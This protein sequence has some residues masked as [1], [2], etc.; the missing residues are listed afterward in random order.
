MFF[1]KYLLAVAAVLVSVWPGNGTAGD[2]GNGGG[3]GAVPQIGAAQWLWSAGRESECHLRKPFSLTEVPVAASIVITADN[4][5]E[6][7]VNGTW[8]GSDEGAGAEVWQSV[9]RYDLKG[10]LARGPNVIAIHGGDLGGQAGVV[11]AVR[12]EFKDQPPLEFATDGTWK[13]ARQGR[14]SDYAHPEFVESAAWTAAT[15]V[16]PMGM[17]PW[18]RLAWSA[19][20]KPARTVGNAPVALSPPDRDFAWPGELIFLGDDCSVYV[21]IRGDAWG[22]CFR[23]G[24]WSRA[25][26]EFDLPCPS[27]IGRKLFRLRP[28]SSAPQPTLLFDA[29]SGCIGSP[30]V[31]YDGRGIFMS[32]A[33]EG[34]KFFHIYQI[35]LAGGEPRRLTEGPFHDLDPVELPDG[36]IAFSSTR[37]GTFEEYHSPPSRALFVMNADGGDIHP[38]TSTPIFDNEPKVMADGRLIF[39]RSDNFFDRAKVETHLHAIRPDGT[40]G[41]T[42]VG[43]EVGPEYGVR[44]RAF[45]YGSPAPLPDGRLA[46]ISNRGNFVGAVGGPEREFHRLPDSLGDLAPLPDGRLLATVLRR[47]GRRMTSDVI[48]VIDPRD[49]RLVPIFESAAGSV[50]SPVF[51]GARARPPVLV[52]SI[53]RARAG[54]PGATGFLFCQDVRF[55]QNTQADWRQI[56]AMRVLGAV[57]LTTRSSHSHIVHAGHETVELGTVPIAP[58]GSFFVEVPADMPL[59][60]Q[61]V[62]AEG[63]SELNEMSWIYVRP[64]ERRSCLG[65][66]HPRQAA[67]SVEKR[68]ALALQA[69]PLKLLGQGEPHRFRGN[70]SGVTGMMDLQFERFRETASLNRH[71]DVAGPLTTGRQ[72]IE[73]LLRQLRGADEGLK[74]SAAQRLA[75]RRDHAA[76]GVLVERLQDSSREVR[77]AAAL[78]LAACGTRESVPGLL[79]AMEDRDPVVAAAGGMALANLVGGQ[80]AQFNAFAEMVERQRQVGV[81][82]DWFHKFSWAAIE[83][84]VI[85]RIRQQQLDP[86]RWAVTALGHVGGEAAR[87]ALREFVG[88]MAAQNPYP[89]F[90][91]DNRTDTFTYSAASP[92]NPR[93]LQEAVR[94]LGQLRDVAAIPLLQRLVAANLAPKTA[95][96][97]LAEAALEALGRIATPEAEA[98]LL[99]LFPRFK[100]YWEYVGWYSDHPA[101]YAC[102]SSPLHARLIEA[103]EAIASPRAAALVPGLIRSVPTDPDR[104]LFLSNDAYE[105]LVGRVIRRSGRG[106]EVVDTC[107]AI[108]GDPQARAGEEIKAAVAA[109]WAAWA[110]HPG[111]ENRAAQILSLVCR[112]RAEEPRIRKAFERYRARP[113]ESIRRELGNPT[114]TPVRHWV[115]FYLARSLGHLRDPNS[116]GAL[117]GVLGD[118]LN[119]ARHGRPDPAQPEIHFLHLEYTPCWRAAAAHALGWIGDRRAVPVLLRAV[120]NLDNAPDVRHAAA[121]ALGR[122]ADPASASALHELAEQYPEVST[123]RVLFAAS[124][125]AKK[126]GTT[127]YGGI[128]DE[129]APAPSVALSEP[130]TRTL[131]AAEAEAVLRRDWLFQAEGQPLAERARQEIRWARALA[132]RLGRNARAPNL[133]R[134]LE[135]LTRLEREWEALATASSSPRTA[136][137]S[138]PESAARDLYWRVRE[139]KRRIQFKN[140]VVD[141]SQVLFID[142]PYPAG[143]EWQ[144]QV[145]HRNGMMA[146]PGGRL[147]VLDGLSPGGRVRKLAP[148]QPASFWRPDLSFD[149]QR[150]LF[151]MKRQDEKSFHLYEVN[152]DGS[153]LRQIT[154]GPYDDLDPIYLPSGQIIF[155]TTRG[156]TYIRCMPYT[157]SYILGRCDADGRNLYLISGSSEPEWLPTLLNDGRVLFSRWDYIDKALW[158]IESLWTCRQDGTAVETFWGNQSVWPDHLGEARPIPGSDRVMFTGLAHHDWFAGSLGLIN[159]N[160][161]RNFPNGLTKVTADV[162]WPECGPPPADPV[163]S[164]DYH[165]AG[166][167]DAYKSPAPLSEEDFLVSARREGKFRLYLMDVHGNRELIYEGAH[168][169]WHA[170]PVKPRPM[171]PRHSDLV[172]WPGQGPERGPLEPGVFYSANVCQGVPELS[173]ERVKY[174]RVLQMDHK[175][176]SLWTRDGRFSGPAVSALQDD[177]VKRILGTVPVAADGSVHFKVP[178]NVVLYFQ[179]LDEHQRALQTMRSSTSVMPGERRGCVGC[180]EQHTIAPLNEGGLAA[181]RTP[182]DLTPPVW[183]TASLS[184]ERL[185]QP[186]LDQYCGHCHQGAGEGRASLD[187]TL[188]PGQ[189]VFK[190]PYLTLIGPIGFGLNRK[191]QPAGIAGAI[192]CENFEMSDPESYATMRPLQYLS[193]ASPLVELCRAGW[194]YDVMLDPKSLQTLMGWIDANCPYRGDEDIRAIPDPEFAGVEEL[195][196]RPRTRTA[197]AVTRP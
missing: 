141:F 167:F 4:E 192:M 178:P 104:A 173:P 132:V 74:I 107:L 44:L 196:I 14:P 69:P 146:V 32:M 7:Y 19:D 57:G 106:G 174:L 24:D 90:E 23:I 82:R 131:S 73:A 94:A 31:S 80:P 16:G 38:I 189:G 176:Y 35:P 17:A 180:H 156:N 121:E 177:G 33:Q 5:Y 11:A 9:E 93:L 58:D 56:R 154:E 66:H 26:T 79:Q 45:G 85:P 135:A 183:G 2:A 36:R 112:D 61:A 164:A 15:V 153:N 129:Y 181:R 118:E 99:E 100:D 190:E 1:Q 92:L 148:D 48:A 21:P 123:R 191:S 70:N 142:H 46:F 64:G 116:V 27:K 197:P 53:D 40:D 126:A 108:L 49:N 182:A 151:C 160:A 50:H 193:Y 77:V 125:A 101:L 165:T 128:F 163:E 95:N 98:A 115:L 39:V 28:G 60:F 63:R 195:P 114:W 147:L 65:C 117:V 105:T 175:T 145:R 18:G 3:A 72:E 6:L 172:T 139:V 124:E 59:A 111:P 83:Q 47:E 55:T 152:V 161:G 103:L 162:P 158:R 140:P 186:I 136:S 137:A 84:T 179:L 25:Y 89:A 170:L 159:P 171:P 62:D 110:G 185:V 75:L 52:D 97:Y 68:P 134:E 150:V 81:W 133:D 130:V 20:P 42:E 76:A 143:R 12:L 166:K 168:H 41:L 120:E 188:R 71:P 29:G 30:S 54:R 155:S 13:V 78:G 138:S 10:L 194:H 144:H 86:P 67:P 96:L 157:Y 122:I 37:T 119:E 184:Y 22:V 8:I 43:A 187:L 127:K 51:A 169:V 34:E 109:T 91:R 102:H 88:E 87:S 113:E 149:G